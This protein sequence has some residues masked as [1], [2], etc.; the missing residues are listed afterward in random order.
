[1][2]DVCNTPHR[3]SGSYWFKLSVANQFLRLETVNQ[4]DRQSLVIIYKVD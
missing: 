2:G 4:I 1:M 3:N